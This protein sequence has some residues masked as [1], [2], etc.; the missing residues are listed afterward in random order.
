M[1]RCLSVTSPIVPESSP[2]FDRLQVMEAPEKSRAAAATGALPSELQ[3]P[4]R[5]WFERLDEQHGLSGLPDE[6][7]ESLLR[8]VACSEFAADAATQEL[9]MVP[10]KRCIVQRGN[11][12]PGGVRKRNF[13]GRCRRAQ[14]TTPSASKSKYAAYSLAGSF[15]LADLDETL[16][17]LSLLAD[18]TLDVATRCAERVLQSRYG[19][20]RDSEGRRV[21]LVTLGMGKLGGRELNFSSDIDLIFLY[22]RDGE[23]DG[24]R[25]ISAQEYF[26]RL[27]RQI[28]ALIDE[29]TVDG[30][31]FRIDTRLR[32]FGESGPPVVSFAALESY[33]SAAWPRMGA[34][35]LR[36]SAHCWLAAVRVSDRRARK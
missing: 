17:Q 12:S 2:F 28:I 1:S 18:L 27:T 14:V 26:G 22:T 4:V 8:F 31:V 16:Q 32:P 29:V 15:W 21:P 6:H 5:Q 11:G 36:Q 13:C 7:I 34:L 33:L 30:F 19:T 10:R 9:A 24:P 35:C 23:T 20:V 3:S 25:A